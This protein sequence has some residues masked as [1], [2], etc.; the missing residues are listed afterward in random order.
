MQSAGKLVPGCTKCMSNDYF[1]VPN[2][3]MESQMVGT[4]FQINQYQPWNSAVAKSQGGTQAPMK[5]SVF[6]NG[7]GM[8][9]KYFGNSETDKWD[10][11]PKASPFN[12]RGFLCTSSSNVMDH[13]VSGKFAEKFREMRVFK[14]TVAK[15]VMCYSYNAQAGG[16]RCVKKTRMGACNSFNIR[17]A[18][19]DSGAFH[20][21]SG[22]M[23]QAKWDTKALVKGS[24]SL[25]NEVATS[26][27]GR[28]QCNGPWRERILAVH[29]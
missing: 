23:T 20:I 14:A 22:N 28:H 1:L 13:T 25:A 9:T 12:P 7:K 21:K 2:H 16:L 5:C 26:Q 6:T 3:H 27:L 24:E 4:C 29:N 11:A 17:N 18:A 8:K 19:F 15:F 10:S